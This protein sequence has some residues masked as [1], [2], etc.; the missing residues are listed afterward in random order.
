MPDPP[1]PVITR[2]GA[3][4]RGF[5][6]PGG[7]AV[8]QDGQGTGEGER[9]AADDVVRGRGSGREV[10]VASLDEHVDHPGQAEAL[11]V[12]GREDRHAALLEQCDLLRD[13]DAA[14]AAEHLHMPVTRLDEALL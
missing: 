2:T 14:S 5:A 9:A 3:P 10:D 13:D 1:V 4:A 6:Q 11:A 8:L 7:P 12:L